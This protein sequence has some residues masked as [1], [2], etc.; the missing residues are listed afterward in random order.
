[1]EKICEYCAAPR[2]IVY[3]QA[4]GAFLCLS[5]DSKVHSANALSSRHS[6]TLLCDSCRYNPVNFRCLDHLMLLC[7]GCD[8]RLHR[9]LPQHKRLMIDGFSGCPSAKSFADLWGFG[10]NELNDFS[11]SSRQGVESCVS[12]EI[13]SVKSSRT[14]YSVAAAHETGADSQ[15][16]QEPINHQR[17]QNNCLIMQQILDLKK[18]QLSEDNEES[19][20]LCRYDEPVTPV[21]VYSPSLNVNGVNQQLQRLDSNIDN[22]QSLTSAER[23]TSS[24]QLDHLSGS[25]SVGDLFWQ[26]DQ[27][28]SQTIQDLG[29]CEEQGYSDV[30][31]IPNLDA[32]FNNFEDLFTS[33]VIRTESLLGKDDLMW[34]EI[35]KK[36]TKDTS[37]SSSV[38]VN[39]DDKK[40][41][42]SRKNSDNQMRLSGFPSFSSARL[43]AESCASECL[44]SRRSGSSTR[45]EQLSKERK[46]TRMHCKQ[47]P[48][49]PRKSKA[50]THKRIKS[51]CLKIE[52]TETE[53]AS[54]TKG[55]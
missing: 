45:G 55:Y 8:S 4:D 24:A 26:T 42:Q 20:L 40:F 10:E 19:P 44:D 46:K 38:Y 28:W 33:D 23:F 53:A 49:S 30:F 5:C 48:L 14:S 6:R 36:T 13:V 7:R 25:S 54:V 51:R 29:V 18:L 17:E 27:I 1:M 31:N 32:T 15:Q 41:L 39:Q 43:S 22:L 11:V 12:T 2:P 50:D 52:G 21:P 47:T 3:C 9:V 35:E 34:S 16:Y 37:A